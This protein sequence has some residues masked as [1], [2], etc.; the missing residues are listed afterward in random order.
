MRSRLYRAVALVALLAATLVPPAS[1][2]ETQSAVVLLTLVDGTACRGPITGTTFNI[3]DTRASYACTDGRWILGEPYSLADGR[4]VAMLART[5]LQGQRVRDEDEPCQQLSCPSSV[6]LVEVATAAT[7]PRVLIVDHVPGKE[8]T[9][10]SFQGGETFYLGGVRANYRCDPSF[11]RDPKHPYPY[12]EAEY[13]IIG[14]LYD[15]GVG[16][17]RMEGSIFAIL[18]QGTPLT[19]NDKLNICRA[20]VCVATTYPVLAAHVGR[21]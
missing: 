16:A 2:G 13:W 11:F 18:R 21:G 3:V 8:S 1:A 14:G 19:P 7:L 5:I 17:T 9:T 20:A 15:P 10:C 4:Q 12:P 6:G